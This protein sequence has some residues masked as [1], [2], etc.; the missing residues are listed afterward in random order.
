MHLENR[1]KGLSV[2]S[3]SASEL[4]SVA[5]K[6]GCIVTRTTTGGHEGKIRYG[7]PSSSSKL[8]HFSA[9]PFADQR[10]SS[11]DVPTLIT[12]SSFIF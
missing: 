9:Q 12:A 6:S 10:L 4:Q 8:C 5:M 11:G 1:G 3:P 7:E 2:K